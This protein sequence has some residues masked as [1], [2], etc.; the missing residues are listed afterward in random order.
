MYLYRAVPIFRLS[1]CDFGGTLTHEIR[2][3]EKFTSE[4]QDSVGAT[5]E[6]GR[7]M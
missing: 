6:G 7:S 1:V 5:E 4:G 2:I 3:S